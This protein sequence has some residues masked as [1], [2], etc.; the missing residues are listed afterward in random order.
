M[1]EAVEIA[2]AVEVR[3]ILQLA[4]SDEQAAF[5]EF[6]RLVDVRGCAEVRR[7]LAAVENGDQRAPRPR[8]TRGVR[9]AMSDTRSLRF[10]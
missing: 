2:C 10:E 7:A 5:A 8:L 1:D 3:I 4:H 9:S 6:H